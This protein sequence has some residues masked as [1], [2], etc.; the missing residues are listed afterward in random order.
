MLLGEGL[1]TKVEFR[2]R[3]LEPELLTL[4]V[5]GEIGGLVSILSTSFGVFLS[6]L[7]VCIGVLGAFPH[8]MESSLVGPNRGIFGSEQRLELGDTL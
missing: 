4:P 2:F 3:F 7:P 8:N 5:G 1:T 6:E